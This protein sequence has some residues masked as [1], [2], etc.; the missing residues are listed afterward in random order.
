MQADSAA[1]VFS[2]KTSRIKIL[3]KYFEVGFF[4]ILILMN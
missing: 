3:K 4:I 1:I 2:L